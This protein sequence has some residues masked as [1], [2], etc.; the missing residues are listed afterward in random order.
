ML[1]ACCVFSSAA[2]AIR[3]LEG[4]DTDCGEV[5]GKL[6]LNSTLIS[7]IFFAVVRGVLGVLLLSDISFRSTYPGVTTFPIEGAG[8]AP[9]NISVTS[10]EHFNET[11][12]ANFWWYFPALLTDNKRIRP[13][14]P[15]NCTTTDCLSYFM[16]GSLSSVILDPSLP[17][18]T[19]NQFPKAISYITND[20]PGYQLDFQQIDR[21]K[22]PNMMMSDCRLYGWETTAIQICLKSV[23]N[24]MLAGKPILENSSNRSMEFMSQRS[25]KSE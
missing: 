21:V 16:P 7:R 5:N 11:A 2:V 6:K 23:D 24:S 25:Q 13:A 12:T 18:I 8:V 17:P 4:T 1:S 19:A 14:A 3:R 9:L 22:D 20:A 10:T 15:L